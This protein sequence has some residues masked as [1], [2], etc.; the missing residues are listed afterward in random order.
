MWSRAFSTLSIRAFSSTAVAAAAP[1]DFA[2]AAVAAGLSTN[3]PRRQRHERQAEGLQERRTQVR[4]A[5]RA[6]LLGPL[7]QPEGR[8][9]HQREREDEPVA[10]HAHGGIDHLRALIPRRVQRPD[11]GEELV[12]QDAS[13]DGADQEHERVDPAGGETRRR[14]A[15]A[16]GAHD[17]SHAEQQAA[18]DLGA[19]D[20]RHEEDLVQLDPAERHQIRQPQHGGDERGE[21]HLH[22]GH[23]G[24]VEDAGQTARTAEAGP[25]QREAEAEADQQREEEG[26]GRAEG[27]EAVEG[28]NHAIAS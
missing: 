6:R 27:I 1:A 21:H 13:A 4:R 20:G 3:K 18:H 9:G 14:R 22:D 25:L 2:E 16:P 5:A 15:G 19:V 12:E 7:R 10:R 17:E 11:H 28:V 24:E 23:V 8:H 26:R